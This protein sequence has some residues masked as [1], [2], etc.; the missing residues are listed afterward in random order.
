MKLETRFDLWQKVH[1]D[2]DCSMTFTVLG[3]S[4]FGRGTEYTVG[5]VADGDLRQAGIDEARL[6]P[7]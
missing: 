3:V 5:W 2:N 7:A 6:S 1:V 4:V